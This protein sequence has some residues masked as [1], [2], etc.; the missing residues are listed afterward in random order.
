MKRGHDLTGLMKFAT[1][2]E[3]AD[4]LHDALDD[5]LGPVLTQFD[6]DSDELPGIIGDHWAMT[7]WGCAFE[8]LVTRVVVI[9]AGQVR[10]DGDR[11]TFE[12]T[13]TSVLHDHNHHHHDDELE[14]PDGGSVVPVTIEVPRSAHDASG[15]THG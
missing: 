9:D 13:S 7:L 5:H 11:A 10:F 6:I 1:R 4:D 2:P 14:D 15:R 8:D 12:R 3:W